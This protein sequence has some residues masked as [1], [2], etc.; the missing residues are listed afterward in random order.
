MVFGD[1]LEHLKDPER[2]LRECASVL[3]SD[4]E[5]LACIPNLMHYSVLHGLL[6]GNFTY[7]DTG[8]LDRT[9][10]L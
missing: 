4:G 9:M 7:M 5:I 10:K 3:K 8:L 2:I 6:H 1:V